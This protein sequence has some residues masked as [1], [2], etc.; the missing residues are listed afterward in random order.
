MSI[1][2]SEAY[3][4]GSMR[5]TQKINAMHSVRRPE[6]FGRGGRATRFGVAGRILA[7]LIFAGAGVALA[8]SSSR[9]VDRPGVSELLHQLSSDNWGIRQSAQQ[10]LVELG[11]AALPALQSALKKN[12]D[13]EAHSRVESAIDQINANR[14]TGP[15]IITLDY[16]A[17]DARTVLKDLSRQ[18]QTEIKIHSFGM[19]APAAPLI[20]IH[21]HEQ[22]FWIAFKKLCDASGLRPMLN[23]SDGME[24]ANA[25][26]D[27]LGGMVDCTGPF[28]VVARQIS[29][30]AEL[31]L[32]RPEQ[33]RRNLAV[34]L[35]IFAEPKLVMVGHSNM[36]TIDEAVD[37]LGNS[38]IDGRQFYNSFNVQNNS[39]WSVRINL[40]R[41]DSKA[42]KIA[43]LRGSIT[44]A[45]ETKSETWTIPDILHAHDLS[46]DFGNCTFSIDSLAQTQN[47]YMLRVSGVRVS[48]S[49]ENSSLGLGEINILDDKGHTLTRHGFG[50]G[51]G[52]D[53]M[54]YTFQFDPDDPSNPTGAPAKLVWQVPVQT[55]SVRIPFNF[56]DLP[57][58]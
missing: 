19:R 58:P 1:V 31:S 40:N 7:T 34:E 2:V 37:D 6:K 51:G 13:L 32:E 35:T 16:D 43:K 29:D 52:P 23:G 3:C 57:I 9:P 36:P 20:T 12:L 53:R 54:N 41:Q 26:P 46:R 4:Y 48:A 42:T 8:S 30:S 21:V 33:V 15:S 5:Q 14:A 39:V 45:I 44:A 56:V 22:P 50:G 10:K 55:K 28:M 49:P 18:A 27:I 11:D 17:T 47:S 38:L 24:L 25:G